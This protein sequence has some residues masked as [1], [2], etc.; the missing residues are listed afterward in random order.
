MH[1]ASLHCQESNYSSRR[2]QRLEMAEQKAWKDSTPLRD[3]L[4]KAVICTVLFLVI[5]GIF[6]G[7]AIHFGKDSVDD[8]VDTEAGHG[9]ISAGSVYA[10]RR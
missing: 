3:R 4:I 10:F 5:I 6:V 1:Y 2:R 7:V 9:V 8:G